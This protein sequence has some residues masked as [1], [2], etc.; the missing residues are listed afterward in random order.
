MRPRLSRRTFCTTFAGLAVARARATQAR[1]SVPIV[2]ILSTRGAQD[3]R[4]LIKAFRQGL[5]TELGGKSYT[6]EERWA[7]GDYSRLPALAADLLR[8]RPNLLFTPGGEPSALAAKTATNTVPIVFIIGGDA[9]KLGL[10]QSYARPGGNATGFSILTSLM[11]AKRLEVL[12]DLLPNARVFGVL[13]NPNLVNVIQ[14]SAEVQNA[15][16]RFGDRLELIPVST[17][18]GLNRLPNEL[19]L[20]QLDALLVTADPFF[21]MWQKRIVAIVAQSRL[22]AIYQARSYV[23]AGGLISYGISFSDVYRQ[24]GTYA[25]RILK[26]TDP[27]VLPVA[28]P[29]Q[30]ELV[31]NLPTARLIGITIPELLLARATELVQ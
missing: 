12:N 18:T 27:G 2:G 21:D 19:A 10:A 6:I 14:Q 26:G 1:Q 16:R 3:S 11:E 8:Q 4:L 15:A 7:D 24:A 9:V 31:I 17:V 5:D 20:R 23:F 28:Q 29:T 25:G 13:V 30:F 22:P